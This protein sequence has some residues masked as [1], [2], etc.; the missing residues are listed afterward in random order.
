M[1]LIERPNMS[2]KSK[3]SMLKKKMTGIPENKVKNQPRKDFFEVLEENENKDFAAFSF[4][5]KNSGMAEKRIVDYDHTQ[6]QLKNKPIPLDQ[7]KFIKKQD[8]Q[9]MVQGPH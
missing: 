4:A 9:N 5:E 8:G 6:N 2:D 1:R 3:E 7:A